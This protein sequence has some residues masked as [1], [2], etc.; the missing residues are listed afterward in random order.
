MARFNI[1]QLE[2]F[3]V[4]MESESVTRAAQ[5]LNVTQP[6]VS[7]SLA[8]LE[9]RIGVKLFKRAGSRLHPGADAY[10]FHTEVERLL[11]QADS[12]EEH[13]ESIRH[14][15]EGRLA[16]SSIPTLASSLVAF[17]VGRVTRARPAVR[18][19][20]YSEISGR[21]IEDVN[22]LRVDLGFV[23]GSIADHSVASRLIGES[24][25][26]CVMRKDHRLAAHEMVTPRDLEGEAL[27]FLDALAPPSHLVRETF[28]QAGVLPRVR[29]ETNLSM[30]AKAAAL[31]GDGV[32]MIDPLPML[33]EPSA[34]LAMR[35]FRPRVP[36]RINCLYPTQRPLSQLAI[37]FID[38]VRTV[39][40]EMSHGNPFV[41]N[42]GEWASSTGV[43]S[44]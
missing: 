33:I 26:V 5:R 28:A 43:Q 30:A 37:R 36:L 2:V 13:I 14:A 39:V 25:I 31:A 18:V 29:I 10:R 19:E 44:G 35:G 3:H 6:A 16:V 41:Q 22:H 24:E 1:R 8:L 11:R 7:K 21:V 15:E 20:L 17:G 40:D 42:S 34:D 27:I 12:L 38:E 9:D 32:A 4:V 23:H